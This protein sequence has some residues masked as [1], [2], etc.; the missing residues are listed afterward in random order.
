MITPHENQK[1]SMT[2]PSTIQTFRSLQTG[3]DERERQQTNRRKHDVW[4]HFVQ[5]R[6]R[7]YSTCRFENYVVASDAQRSAVQKVKA[8]AENAPT[9]FEDGRGL[10]LIGPVGT[11]KDHLFAAAI[12][13]AIVAGAFTAGGKSGR[14]QFR[15]G[16]QLIEQLGDAMTDRDRQSV[17]TRPLTA[18]RL[19][20]LSDVCQAGSAL[21]EFHRRMLYRIVDQRYSEC[22]PA[23]LSANVTSPDQLQQQIGVDLFDRLR[24]G[25]TVVACSWPS[26]RRT[27]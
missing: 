25:A 6:G 24:H 1:S 11:G 22:R 5:Q 20:V 26:F 2:E 14:V 17:I 18:A 23:W 9:N 12:F 8:Y 3:I 4:Q 7:R 16:P 15:N 19:L 27:A 13:S 10:I 21:S